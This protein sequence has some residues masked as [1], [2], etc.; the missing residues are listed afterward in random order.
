VGITENVSCPVNFGGAIIGTRQR[1]CSSSTTLDG[2][3]TVF[4][5]T[6]GTTYGSEAAMVS[7]KCS[8]S[9]TEYWDTTGTVANMTRKNPPSPA[10]F[11]NP[12]AN[13]AQPYPSAQCGFRK[14]T[15]DA[16]NCS[17][18]TPSYDTTNCECITGTQN[19]FQ[20]PTCT[21][22]ENVAT[23]TSIR[24]IR[25]GGS[26]GWIDDPTNV[27]GNGIV[28]GTC[29]PKT[30]IWKSSGIPSGP[31][32]ANNPGYPKCNTSC[33]CGEVAT[34]QTCATFQNNTQQYDFFSSTC[35]P[36]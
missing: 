32:L 12:V 26:C 5:A 4:T 16:T 8:C 27:I 21:S 1:V 30:F 29:T 34:S 3:F 17:W 28:L 2:S 11:I 22:C 20:D 7:A 25:G 18:I 13:W 15:V 33:L 10:S 23:Q 36:L 24:Q 19:R 6:D 35:Q 31:S 9:K 14:I